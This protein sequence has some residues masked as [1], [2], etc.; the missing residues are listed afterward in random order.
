VVRVGWP[1]PPLGVPR[2]RQGRHWSGYSLPRLN[3]VLVQF[4]QIL[5]GIYGIA[6]LGAMGRKKETQRTKLTARVLP[7][8]M[9]RIRARKK[10]RQ[11]TLG[12][13]IDQAFEE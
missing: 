9:V 2:Y 11:T 3:L 13:V 8:T 7:E 12:K 6:T 1:W 4:Q 5:D 10:K